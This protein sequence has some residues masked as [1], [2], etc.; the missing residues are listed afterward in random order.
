MAVDAIVRDIE[1]TILKPSYV[2]VIAVVGRI[3]DL[4]EGVC[5]WIRCAICD[6]N[7]SGIVPI[8]RRFLYSVLRSMG[9]D[10]TCIAPNVGLVVAWSK[11]SS[12]GDMREE[13]RAKCYSKVRAERCKPT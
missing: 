8:G 3:F 7:S 10:Q 13:R 4:G 1:L 11:R 5:Q 6:Q 12:Q 9:V 2:N